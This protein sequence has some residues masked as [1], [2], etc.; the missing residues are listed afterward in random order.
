LRDA[1][2]YNGAWSRHPSPSRRRFGH[3][4][5]GLRGR[6][7]ALDCGVDSK[8]HSVAMDSPPLADGAAA[9]PF[10]IGE[11]A[12]ATALT[13][14]TLR[15][16]ERLGLLATPRRS[17]G[18]FRLFGQ[19][20]VERVRFV[21]RAQALGLALDE[22]RQ[23]IGAPCRE[24]EPVLRA[25]LADLD[26]RLDELRGLRRTL[27]RALT[28]CEQ[29]VSSHPDAACPVVE[30]LERDA[31]PRKAPRPRARAQAPGRTGH[32]R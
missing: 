12:A 26:A 29:Q 25:R 1:T 16:Y 28:D 14:D 6:G 2:T 5:T 11:L 32:S 4:R 31:R 22:I 21:K 7:S 23:L 30:E 15:Y 10:R 24:V 3:C 27:S 20:A 17:A 8:V 13:R 18:G 19:D 9:P